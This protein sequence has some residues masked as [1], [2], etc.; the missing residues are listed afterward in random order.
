M[1]TQGSSPRCSEF[2]FCQEAFLSS[3]FVIFRVDGVAIQGVRT[4]H[5][6][7]TSVCTHNPVNEWYK[8]VTPTTRGRGK[9]PP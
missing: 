4:W 5:T 6:C 7:C 9:Y 2:P 1:L 3:W 8:D